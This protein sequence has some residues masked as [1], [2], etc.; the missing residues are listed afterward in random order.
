MKAV[1]LAAGKGSRIE[2]IS[3]GMPKS[4]IPFKNDTILGFSLTKIAKKGIRSLVVVTGYKSELIRKYIIENW[5][6][7]YEFVFNERYNETNVL[8]SFYLS[9]PFIKSDD[10]LFLHAD[11]IFSEAIITDL[12]EKFKENDIVFPV[13][14][15]KC[16]D[17]EMKV[18]VENGN[19]KK[20]SKK[21]KPNESNGEFLGIAAIKNHLLEKVELIAKKLFI[22]KKYESFF[23]AA[24][25]ILIDQEKLNV[26]ALSVKK[27]PWIEID[28]PE[29]FL[30]AVKLFK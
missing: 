10:F 25:Q 15:K 12:L 19:I 11:T 24:I 6:Y 29:D 9:I 28:T 20:I 27:E 1:I 26:L 18:K 5:K 17:E 7:D 8:Y 4:L 3:K 22:E 14:Y 30:D 23:E 21:I 2:K 13:E 16:G